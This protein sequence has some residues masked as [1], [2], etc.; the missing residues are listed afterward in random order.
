MSMPHTMTLHEYREVGR[1]LGLRGAHADLAALNVG[2]HAEGR[3]LALETVER[4]GK[5]DVGVLGLG[6]H[7]GARARLVCLENQGPASA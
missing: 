7:S 5:V 4:L 1:T 2:V 6:L 3:V